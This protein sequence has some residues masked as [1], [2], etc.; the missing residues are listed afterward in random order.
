M[1]KVSFWVLWAIL[2]KITEPEEGGHENP[3]FIA[4]QLEVQVA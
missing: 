3:W 2:T 1:S 4:S